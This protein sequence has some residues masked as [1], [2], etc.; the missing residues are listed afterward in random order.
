[1]NL[2]SG[3]DLVD[4]EEVR[5]EIENDG[6]AFIQTHFSPAE[7]E[8]CESRKKM[9]HEHYA[10]RLVVKRAF[11]KAVGKPEKDFSLKEI[12]I[13]REKG[14]VPGL[15]LSES[16]MKK[17]GLRPPDKILVSLAHERKIAV[18]TVVIVRGQTPFAGKGV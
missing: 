1:M 14:H 8:Y 9:R 18:G 6:G 16:A 10:G 13:T 3:I 4:V 2:L 7:I 11:L 12:E 17:A 15:N 5:L